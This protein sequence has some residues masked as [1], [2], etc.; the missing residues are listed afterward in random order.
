MAKVGDIIK[1]D[2]E[3]YDKHSCL[4]PSLPLVIATVFSCREYLLPLVPL[5]GALSGSSND[6]NFLFAEHRS[7]ALLAQIPA[8]LVLYAMIRRVPSGDAVARWIWKRGRLFL[9]A[10]LLVDLCRA[11]WFANPA[12]VHMSEEGVGLLASMALNA[13]ILLYVLRSERVKDSFADFPAAA[14]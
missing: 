3:C 1:Y 6:M 5:A 14:A 10:S 8:L 7:V 11:A 12:F 9:A 13:G 2:F 4:K